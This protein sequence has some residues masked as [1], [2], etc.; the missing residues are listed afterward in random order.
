MSDNQ[1]KQ[2][3]TNTFDCG[4]DRCW[5][6][7][8]VVPEITILNGLRVCS[9]GCLHN[10][11]TRRRRDPIRP[12]DLVR[13]ST[14]FLQA[15]QWYTDVPVNGCVLR[16]RPATK[17][18]PA[19]FLVA[20]SN[21]RACSVLGPNIERC[22]VL[23]D[24]EKTQRCPEHTWLGLYVEHGAVNEDEYEDGTEYTCNYFSDHDADE[25]AWHRSEPVAVLRDAVDA[26][27]A[28]DTLGRWCCESSL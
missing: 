13:Y 18:V 19:I 7:L 16:V 1:S 14:G 6:C 20:W 28:K 15:S 22:S 26:W 11:R 12:G 25:D 4:P 10:A 21:G 2:R 17:S 23:V 9:P 5:G 27:L 8:Q 3:E 24:G